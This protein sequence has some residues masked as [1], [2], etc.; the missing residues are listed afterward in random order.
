MR[1]P[2]FN[3]CDLES[4]YV[5]DKDVPGLDQ[6]VKTA[7]SDEML[8]ACRYWGPHLM[9]TDISLELLGDLGNFLSTR[10]LLW[11]EVMNLKQHMSTGVGVLHQV[12][13]R[14]QVSSGFL[15]MIWCFLHANRT[16][17]GRMKFRN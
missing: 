6:R 8:Y 13:A 3:I 16:S 1:N 12:Q 15:R 2:P 4:S 5:F 11:M 9:L 10:L 7:I 17:V 14:L